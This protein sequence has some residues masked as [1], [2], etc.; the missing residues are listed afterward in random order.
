MSRRR[1]S[2]PSPT[3][4]G[5]PAAPTPRGAF[6]VALA[7]ALA[8][9]A[10]SLLLTRLHAR[11]HAG[12][13]SFCALND[14]VN[15]DRVATSRFSVVLGLPVAVWGAF[16]Y[17]LAGTLAAWGLA[18]RQPR[19]SWPSGLLFLVASA[20]VAASA[21]LALVSEFAIGAWCLLCAGSWAVALALLAAGWRACV[22]IGVAAAVRADL[23]AARDRPLGAAALA[24]GGTA[25]VAAAVALYPRYW[26]QPKAEGVPSPL[27][28]RPGAGSAPEGGTASSGGG[29]NVPEG[30]VIEYSDYECPY[31][32]RAHEEV[33]AVLS[34][35]P[36]ITLVSRHFPLDASCN[37][38]V[39]RTV[40]PTACALARAAIC[41]GAQGRFAEMDDAL[42]RNQRERLA[43][44]RLAEQLGLDMERF[45]A[46]VGSPETE[47]RLAAD[48]AAGLRDG[49]RATPTYLVGHTLSAGRFPLELLPPARR[50]MGAP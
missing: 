50:A 49:V 44:A 47:R 48:V 22:P 27:A 26:E 9:L 6:A 34:S 30:T 19:G 4:A 25:V 7:L 39:A 13:A 14:V 3:P 8:G 38:A 40:H 24:L 35:R 29:V 12:F 17:A 21:A 1:K 37:P 11:A 32:A 10:L 18:K 46:C 2:R 23:A 20:A 43:P 5:R 36:D 41:A 33:R 16:G 15:C 45:G 28:A 31:C 42:F